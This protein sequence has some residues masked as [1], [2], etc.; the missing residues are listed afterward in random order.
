MAAADAR[1][2]TRLVICVDGTQSNSSIAGTGSQTNI[3]R[4]Y[5]GVRRGKCLSASSGQA[6]NQIV[7]YVPGIG[8]ADSGFSTDRIQASVFGQ[9]HL[10]QIQDV[11]ESCCQLNGSKD[12][13]W[14]FGFSRGAYVV[15]AVAGLLHHFG[16][17]ASAGQ[18][19]FAKDFKKLL[20]DFERVQGSSSLSL[21]PVSDRR[22]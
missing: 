1:L 17:I 16:A 7:N 5:A 12:E 22:L 15:R 8:L 19:E 9:G 10:K 20:K 2:P 4:I 6:F 11:Y 21:S 13:V 18:N 3:H 14:L